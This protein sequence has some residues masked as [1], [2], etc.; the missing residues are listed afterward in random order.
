[1][2]LKYTYIRDEYFEKGGIFVG[3]LSV[4]LAINSQVYGMRTTPP[5][6]G[7]FADRWEHVNVLGRA[8]ATHSLFLSF[9]VELSCRTDMLF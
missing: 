6:I 9:A 8:G 3:C 5:A 2:L 7:W 4:G 1:M